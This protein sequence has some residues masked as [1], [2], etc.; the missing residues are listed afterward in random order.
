MK[1]QKSIKMSTRKLYIIS[2][3]VALLPRLIFLKWTYPVN[4]PVDEL[5]MFLPIS[6]I[7][8]WDWSG[9]IITPLY[10]GYGFIS[11]LIPLFAL[12]DDGVLLYRIIVVLMILAQALI[13]PCACYIVRR[14]FEVKDRKITFLIA[15]SCS[16]MVTQR[17]VYVYN[18]FI[19]VFG[20]WVIAII[21]LLLQQ[22]QKNVKKKRILSAILA[23]AMTYE[24]TLHA[25]A[26]TLF[27]ALGILCILYYWTY[28]KHFLSYISFGCIGTIGYFA[29]YYIKNR[30]I[31]AIFA[32]NVGE[33]ANATVKVHLDSIFSSAK[34]LTGWLDITLGQINSML[35]VTA[36]M[37]IFFVVIGCIFI[38]KIVIRDK[39][40]V[41]TEEENANYV[42]LF[43]FFMAAMAMTIIALSFSW[44]G[45]VTSVIEAGG[46]VDGLRALTYLRYYGAYFGPVVL[47]GMV[48]SYSH[49]KQ[50]S[51]LL[52]PCIIIV[53]I[54]QI[55]WVG[56]IVPYIVGFG[57]TS[58]DSSMYSWVN[59]WKDD[60]TFFSYLPAV[61]VVFIGTIFFAWLYR[62]KKYEVAFGIFSLVL[63]Y[64]YSYQAINYEGYR[65]VENFKSVD[66][67]YE[68][69]QK[70]KDAGLLPKTIH[71]QDSG[72]KTLGY[73]TGSML[74][75]LFK[76]NQITTQVPDVTKEE[77]IFL[78]GE[79]YSY[80]GL[81]NNGY[82]CAQ[83][84]NEEFI[85]VKG[86]K[87]Q[88]F[89]ISEGISLDNHLKYDTSME[90][91]RFETDFPKHRSRTQICSDGAEGY[92]FYGY[93]FRYGGGELIPS[94]S[95]ELQEYTE[96]KIGTF[97]FVR[98]NGRDIYLSKDVYAEDF[99]EEGRLK[100]EIP[101]NTYT[102]EAVELRFEVAEGSRVT[103]NDIRVSNTAEYAPGKNNME[104]VQQIKK[105]ITQFSDTDKIYFID[106]YETCKIDT[107][108]L[109]KILE[110]PVEAISWKTLS[111]KDVENESAVFIV[112][113]RK[114]IFELAERCFIV[115]K[116]KN[117][118]LFASEKERNKN[119]VK[120]ETLSDEKGILTKY[121]QL[122]EQG[123]YSPENP[124]VLDGGTYKI[125]A[126]TESE[127]VAD[128]RIR[129]TEY[130]EIVG[131]EP[132]VKK[133]D[134]N[135]GAEV[136]ISNEEGFGELGI[137]ILY[138]SENETEERMKMYIQKIEY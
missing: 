61:V 7:L 81:L 117:F 50:M 6:K 58:F 16:Y 138:P 60:I 100:L 9:M 104:E 1:E 68:V 125:V 78:T 112:E 13:A 115:E 137:D 79:I 95:L 28:R 120:K 107:E 83:L 98:S 130:G 25:R 14:F 59:G 89:L 65:G 94:I 34:A 124:V 127:Q 27:I 26:L 31:G 91:Y 75:F 46:H 12:V 15:V 45:S 54:L 110:K 72:A 131:E 57:E 132:F 5:S 11:F 20:I 3:L 106:P 123:Y 67:S 40:I 111:E 129:V 71:V 2:F 134:G 88:E 21:L 93:R 103:V 69:L 44:L 96:E 99:D 39:W 122:D 87:L 55:I 24:L 80:P 118:T 105:S 73:S 126:S 108:Y 77:G 70:I 38:W 133:E 102:N 35:I 47:A 8:E 92:L 109:T 52:I 43:V 19:Y 10:Y 86:E 48:Y 22:N 114:G 82:K 63:I 53:G 23:L 121:F 42:I 128:C 136:I 62:K 64:G 135:Y 18:E 51:K 4:I 97:E 84:D 76:K 90:L 116:T 101:V 17:A 66:S 33:V 41:Q 36:G 32:E 49:G 37:A 119:Q 85:Y 56:Y 113:G 30:L 74:Q 29:D